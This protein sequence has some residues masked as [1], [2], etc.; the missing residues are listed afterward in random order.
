MCNFQF[1]HP[2]N[3]S[4][5][6]TGKRRLSRRR[7]RSRRREMIK[8]DTETPNTPT[9]LGARKCMRIYTLPSSSHQARAYGFSV[10]CIKCYESFGLNH[11]L[12][13]ALP[14]NALLD[15]VFSISMSVSVL[16]GWSKYLAYNAVGHYL[17]NFEPGSGHLSPFVPKNYYIHMLVSLRDCRIYNRNIININF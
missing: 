11:T 12:Q 3:D 15:A 6:S 9:H 7:G 16:F 13:F 4:V 2:L 10:F 17:V 8:F 1:K 14:R 5:Y